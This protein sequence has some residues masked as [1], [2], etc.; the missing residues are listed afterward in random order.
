[1]LTVLDRPSNTSGRFGDDCTAP[2]GC[3]FSPY[4]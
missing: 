2:A 3:G 4:S 1:L